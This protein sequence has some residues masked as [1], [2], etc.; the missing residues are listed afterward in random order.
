M[1]HEKQD[2]LL[3]LVEPQLRRAA[4]YIDACDE[5]LPTE[6]L[7][8]DYYRSCARLLLSVFRL[9][10]PRR[11]FPRLLDG[12]AAARESADAID[13][14]ARLRA[15]RSLRFPELDR[16]IRKIEHP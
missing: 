10:E 7:D 11:A 2:A 6:A 15:G 16:I 14:E 12:S 13:M 8:P 5:G 9:F 1:S 4:A 3:A